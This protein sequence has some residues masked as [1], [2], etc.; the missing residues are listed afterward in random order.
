M[1]SPL[2]PLKLSCWDLKAVES[3]QGSLAPLRTL[4]SETLLPK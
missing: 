2:A 1:F 3:L 4:E